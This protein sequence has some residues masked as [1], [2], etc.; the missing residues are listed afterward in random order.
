M[1]LRMIDNISGQIL[2]N[3]VLV[4]FA[5]LLASGRWGAFNPMEQKISVLTFASAKDV[6]TYFK[7][8]SKALEDAK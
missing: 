7:L 8:S 4:G 3:G 1:K 6:L 2:D 5:L